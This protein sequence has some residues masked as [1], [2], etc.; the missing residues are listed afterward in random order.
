ML[1]FCFFFFFFSSRRRHTRSLCD[2]SSD[3]CSSDLNQLE[4][5]ICW[6]ERNTMSAVGRF[7]LEFRK[8]GLEAAQIWGDD[9]GPG[10]P[11]IDALFQA[12]W[13]IN[14][15]NFGGKANE[16][17]AYVSRGAEVWTSFGRQVTS[18]EIVLIRD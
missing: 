8:A 18:G 13:R 9:G 4:K 17:L 14:R 16:E 3:V 6:R 10:R 5:L 15:F 7:I 12:G 2:W 11:M 1:M